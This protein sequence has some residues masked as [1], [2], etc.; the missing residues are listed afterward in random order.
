VFQWHRAGFQATLLFVLAGLQN[1]F[2]ATCVLHGLFTKCIGELDTLA[3]FQAGAGPSWLRLHNSLAHLPHMPTSD[4]FL[5]LCSTY[6]LSVLPPSRPL[7]LVLL[8]AWL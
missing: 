1:S 7:S 5:F 4:K 8:K 3:R 6:L 2:A